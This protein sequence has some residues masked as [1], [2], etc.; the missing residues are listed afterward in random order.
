MDSRTCGMFAS[1]AFHVVPLIE[2]ALEPKERTP[3]DAL[4][5][6]QALVSGLSTLR[7]KTMRTITRKAPLS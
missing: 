5:Q 3:L 1:H 4:P 6:V 2:A 7:G